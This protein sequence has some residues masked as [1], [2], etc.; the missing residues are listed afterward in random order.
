MR[1]ERY[2]MYLV[3]DLLYLNREDLM[4]LPLVRRREILNKLLLNEHPLY[5]PNSVCLTRILLLDSDDCVKRKERRMD[6]QLPGNRP[7]QITLLAAKSIRRSP[8][9]RLLTLDRFP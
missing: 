8:K 9:E 5:L 1:P 6:K 3:F 7:G 2:L 4:D